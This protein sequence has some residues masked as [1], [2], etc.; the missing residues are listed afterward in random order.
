MKEA[1]IDIE[2]A[3]KTEKESGV[4]YEA[5]KPEVRSED[6][7][8]TNLRRERN[9]IYLEIMARDMAALRSSLNSYFRWIRTSHAI[10]GEI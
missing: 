4:V 1:R 2:M 8:S 7:A 10:L 9:K 5:L 6:R 3:F